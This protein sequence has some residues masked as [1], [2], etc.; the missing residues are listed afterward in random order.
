VNAQDEDIAHLLSLSIEAKEH[1]EAGVKELQGASRYISVQQQQRF[2]VFY[3]LV[4]FLAAYW[5][6]GTGNA[7]EQG[8]G[9][10]SVVG[11]P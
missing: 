9:S 11:E 8:N 7:A 10:V 2:M 4:M 1:A 3:V 5:M 6:F